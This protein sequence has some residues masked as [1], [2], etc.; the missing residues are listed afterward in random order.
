MNDWANEWM[1]KW[2]KVQE[3]KWGASLHRTH[4]GLNEGVHACVNA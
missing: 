4:E 1:D 2:S 3:R